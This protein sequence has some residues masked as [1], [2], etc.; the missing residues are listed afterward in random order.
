VSSIVWLDDPGPPDGALLGGKGLHLA[1]MTAAGLPVPPGFVVSTAAYARDGVREPLAAE[2]RAAYAQL[3]QREGAPDPIVAV[4][5][6]ATAEDLPDASFA[7]Q[8]ETYLGVRGADEVVARV[9][10]CWA[11]LHGVGAVAY[12]ERTGVAEAGVAMGVVVQLLVEARASGVL[13]T[14]NPSNGDRSKIVVEAAPGLGEAVV[15]GEVTP[16][17]FVVDKV[18]LDVRERH[19]HEQRLAHRLDRATGSVVRVALTS[20]EAAGPAIDDEELLALAR[21]GKRLEQLA[22]GAPQDIEW[23]VRDDGEP[24]LLQCRPETVWSRKPAAPKLTPA[25]GALDRIA[26]AMIPK[27]PEGRQ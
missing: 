11:S 8:Q 12:R 25:L 15:A 9:G 20:Q 22:D 5:S 13:F 23:A 6:S 10:A 16:D 18:T 1:E 21:L 17:R 19:I 24:A 3:A 4:R 2:I 27:Q 14:L 7:G 26:G